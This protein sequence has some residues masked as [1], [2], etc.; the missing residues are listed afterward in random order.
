MTVSNYPGTTVELTVGGARRGDMEARIVDSPGVNSFIPS[1]EDER[2][3]RDLI[4][5]GRT[6][7]ILQVADAKNLKRT[8]L[9]VLELSE[10]GLPFTLNL[11]MMDEALNKGIRIE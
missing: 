1:S 2:V 8:L 3:T 6:D 9:L 7:R 4:L 10:M 5:F 11:N